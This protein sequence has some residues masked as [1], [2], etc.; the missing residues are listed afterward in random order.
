MRLVHR[1]ALPGE[2]WIAALDVGKRCWYTL[3]YTYVV[4]VPRFR[5]FQFLWIV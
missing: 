4:Y 3:S 5:R 1:E 2:Y